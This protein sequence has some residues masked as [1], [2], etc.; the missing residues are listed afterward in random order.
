MKDVPKAAEEA[1]DEL[2][3]LLNNQEADGTLKNIEGVGEALSHLKYENLKKG[4][5]DI[6]ALEGTEDKEGLSDEKI[7]LL[8]RSAIASAD[9]SGISAE[10][11][12]EIVNTY[13]DGNKELLDMINNQ[14][15]LANE[16]AAKAAVLSISYEQAYAQIEARE[17]KMKVGAIQN[18]QSMSEEISSFAEKVS[19]E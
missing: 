8:K 11:A 15:M 14:D 16:A 19:G 5:E 2:T 10:D 7:D 1:G 12:T 6:E 17:E 18:F 13:A 4:L 3:N 9:L